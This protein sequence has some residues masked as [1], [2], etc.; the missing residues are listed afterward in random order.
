MRDGR[1]R[2]KEAG[3]DMAL[4]RE[5]EKRGQWEWENMLRRHNFLG[6]VGELLKQMTRDKLKK[7]N[8]EYEK[9]LEEAREGT[10]NERERMKGKDGDGK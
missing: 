3:D 10:G 4:Q 7:G 1:I 6:F 2:A 8:G 5:E 9:W